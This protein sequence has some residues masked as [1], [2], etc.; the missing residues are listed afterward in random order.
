MKLREKL[1]FGIVLLLL[2]IG[3]AQ[4]TRVRYFSQALDETY[5]REGID[6]T[7]STGKS[8]TLL[9]GS[10][11]DALATVIVQPASEV[12]SMDLTNTR[13]G[14]MNIYERHA[15]PVLYPLALLRFF[16]G[17]LTLLVLCAEIGRAHV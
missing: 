1:I 7:N 12:C 9:T 8:Q 17:S 11:L 3:F 15:W 16:A 5:F 6:T 2:S 10:W 14:Y 13:A 4:L